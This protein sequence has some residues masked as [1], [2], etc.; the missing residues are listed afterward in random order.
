MQ[1]LKME[2]VKKKNNSQKGIHYINVADDDTFPIGV[3]EVVAL[4]VSPDD[5]GDTSFNLG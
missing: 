2:Q 1:A 3:Q 5:L 4:W